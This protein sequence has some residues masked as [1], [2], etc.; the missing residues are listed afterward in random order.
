MNFKNEKTFLLLLC[1]NL[2]FL[3]C[4]KTQIDDVNSQ[5]ASTSTFELNNIQATFSESSSQ[6]RNWPEIKDLFTME[7]ESCFVDRQYANSVIGEKFEIKSNLGVQTIRTK[8]DGCLRW[9]EKFSFNYLKAETYY[10]I[11]GT[12]TGKGN[13]QGAIEYSLAVNPWS[14]KVVYNSGNVEQL[15]SLNSRVKSANTFQNHIRVESFDISLAQTKFFAKETYLKVVMETKPQLSRT[16]LNG[17]ETFQALTSG[18]FKI[19]FH[20]ISASKRDEDRKVIASFSDEN[21]Y[22]AKD[23]KIR[24]TVEF[25][26]REGIDSNSQLE[27]GYEIFAVNSPVKLGVDRGILKIDSLNRQTNASVQRINESFSYMFGEQSRFNKSRNNAPD[28]FG[29]IMDEIHIKSG[30]SVGANA[31]TSFE[32]KIIAK[33]RIEMIDSLVKQP[34]LNHEFN[35]DVIDL[36]TGENLVASY[37][38]SKVTKDGSKELAFDI[39]VPFKV[40]DKRNYRKFLVRV[41]GLHEPFGEGLIKERVVFINPF[42]EGQTDFGI[43]SKIGKLIGNDKV[44]KQE[45]HLRTVNYVAKDNVLSSY[46]LNKN[47]DL[48]FNKKIRLEMQPRLKADQNLA[49]N[50]SVYPSIPDGEYNVRFL[51]LAPKNKMNIDFTKTIDLNDF[52]TL[53]GD[54][55]VKRSE[56]GFL[57]VDVELPLLFSDLTFYSLKT[58]AL[59]EVS[60]LDDSVVP[61]YFVSTFVGSKKVGTL[62]SL[63]ESGKKLSTG[64]VSIAKN[65]IER[66]NGLGSKLDSD[67]RIN[68]NSNFNRFREKVVAEKGVRPVIFQHRGYRRE[69]F[70]SVPKKVTTKVYNSERD[71]IEKEKLAGISI[72]EVEALINNPDAMTS[73]MR[74]L[75]CHILYDENHF[76]SKGMGSYKGKEIAF[77]G[78]LYKRCIKDPN[79]FFSINQIEHIKSITSQPKDVLVSAADYTKSIAY[80]K[81]EGSI[82][83]IIEGNR[84][85]Q[86]IQKGWGAH[87]GLE[88]DLATPKLPIPF[89]MSAVAGVGGSATTGLRT[90]FYNMSQ[91]AEVFLK[92][93]RTSNQISKRIR[94]DR[95]EVHFGAEVKSCIMIRP[96]IFAIDTMNGRKRG[97][98]PGLG[99]LAKV[100]LDYDKSIEDLKGFADGKFLV[101]SSEKNFYLCTEKSSR[102]KLSDT[103]YLLKVGNQSISADDNLARNS[104]VS[105]IRGDKNFKSFRQGEMDQG[106]LVAH[107]VKSSESEVFKNY[108]SYMERKGKDIGFGDRSRRAFGLDISGIVEIK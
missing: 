53:T 94:Y 64:N 100:V 6:N 36:R 79:T 30:R 2:A 88:M 34:I 23:G 15:N 92:Q 89:R 67:R 22:I 41:S 17:V 48:L 76:I 107:V 101:L 59:V 8:A 65:L 108:K 29:F 33:M 52:Y 103:W 86:Y 95:Y 43:D 69:P 28:A 35:V 3:S 81:S 9:T 93:E 74:K 11:S 42:L 60:T 24:S 45:I 40:T 91:R 44:T 105:V 58:I 62:G 61:G 85:S 75:V 16:A 55:V 13:H 97:T 71:L 46:K 4:S 106:T 38:R 54:S 87:A 19:N 49:G 14:G 31:N 51:I 1:L 96:K 10:E 20:L 98:E 84:D 25:N 32:R 21:A 5:Q 57:D 47:L 73:K 82:N 37:D 7:L 18:N 90:D 72:K 63:T 77:R 66:L 50:F 104:F 26:L 83:S 68:A 70:R 39:A 99:T 27:I 56:N 102:K 78:L 80:F 12:V